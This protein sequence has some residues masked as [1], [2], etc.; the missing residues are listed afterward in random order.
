V[1]SAQ[2]PGP[3]PAARPVALVTGVGRLA[4][5][6][7]AISERLAE[8][9]WDV[10]TTY[11]AP[12]DDRMPWGRQ[13]DDPGRIARPNTARVLPATVPSRAPPVY[14]ARSWHAPPARDCTS[15]AGEAMSPG[16]AA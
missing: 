7:A 5:I 3:D 4:G 10:A 16:D 14:A 12:Y 9:G 6:G 1:N 11:W 2:Q 8:T 15:G 13:P